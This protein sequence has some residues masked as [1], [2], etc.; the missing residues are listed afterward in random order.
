GG[1]TASHEIELLDPSGLVDRVQGIMLSGG[2]AMGLGCTAGAVEYF[3]DKM[4]GFATEQGVVPIVPGASLYDFGIGRAGAFPD[5]DDGFKACRSAE[6]DFERGN[7]GAGTGAVVG[8]IRGHAMGTK[9]GLGSAGWATEDGLRVGALAA[10]NAFGDVVDPETGLIIAGARGEDG[11]ALD[12]MRAM[13]TGGHE[14]VRFG[15]NTTLCVVATNAK[16]TKVQAGVVARI[17]QSGIAR[18]VNPCHTQFDG[19]M[20]FV[21]SVQDE[22]NGEMESDLNRVGVLASKMIEAAV[23]DAVLRAESAHGVVCA[24]ELGW[25]A[26]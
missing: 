10:V 20:V 25:V 1:A 18:A 26:G 15:T 23:I 13:V 9:G 4:R 7:V 5:A 8:K 6:V 11:R 2:S 21:L 17:A 16:L 24:G 12:T 3:S 22:A 14:A 19:D